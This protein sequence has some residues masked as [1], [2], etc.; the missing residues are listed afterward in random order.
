MPGEGRVPLTLPII[1]T[2][3][4]LSRSHGYAAS[5]AVSGA[6]RLSSTTRAWRSASPS[7]QQPVRGAA[8]VVDQAVEPPVAGR[9]RGEEVPH[10]G[11]VA[12][13]QRGEGGRAARRGDRFTRRPA[14]ADDHLRARREE[15][16]RDSGA[17]APGSAGDDDDPPA[18]L[19]RLLPSSPN[20]CLVER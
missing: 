10:G 4:R 15:R 11:R 1:T 9:D 13:V 7:P 18:Q 14:G 20:K 5:E 16:T 8:R 3:P 17:N 19:H 2:E 6:S 12:Q